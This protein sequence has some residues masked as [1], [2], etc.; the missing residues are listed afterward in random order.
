MKHYLF[1]NGGSTVG[2]DKE[3]NK[4]YIDDTLIDSNGYGVYVSISKEQLKDILDTKLNWIEDSWD[5]DLRE[6]YKMLK[7]NL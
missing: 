2:I 7:E 3:N 4:Y 5:K 1:I 6:E